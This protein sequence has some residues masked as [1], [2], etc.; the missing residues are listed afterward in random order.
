MEPAK[1]D[2]WRVI[3]TLLPE[4]WREAAREQKAVQRARYG[5]DEAALLRLLLFHAVNGGGMRDTVTQARAAGIAAM[6]HVALRERLQSASAWL[7]WLG[8]ELCRPLRDGVRLPGGLRPRAFD[9]TTVQGPASRGTQWRV[10]YSLD[11][12]SLQCDWFQLTDQHGAE[13]LE[14]T[15][16]RKGDVILGD[17]NYLRPVGVRAVVDAEAH[18]LL[19]LRWTH[20]TMHDAQGKPFGALA[21]ARTLRVGRVGA[22]PVRLL[23]PECDPVAGRV[24]T[25]KLPAPLA[26]KAERRVAHA[27]NKKSRR[28]DP[29]SLEAAHFVMVFTTL[30]TSL[31]CDADVLELYRCRWQI[32][33]AFKRLK[34]LLKLGQLPHKD[35]AAASGWIHAK[36]VIALLLETLYRNAAALS[37]WGYRLQAL[38]Q[39]CER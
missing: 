13:L 8:M 38:P 26:A 14:R 9:S 16:M 4:R 15:P 3:E 22:W 36:M 1:S 10:H 19:R 39:S 27:A 37:P 25:T 31:L 2:E 21:H 17:R 29:R 23:V 33:L 28:P 30:P 32:E 18:A 11:L 24:I 12:L 5:A 34:Q 7:A 20:S 6:S 35:P